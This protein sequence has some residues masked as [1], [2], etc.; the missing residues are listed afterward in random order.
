[1][2]SDHIYDDIPP[3]K[4]SLNIVISILMHLLTVNIENALFFPKREHHERQITSTLTN[5]K[6]QLLMTLYWVFDSISLNILSQC[7]DVIRSNEVH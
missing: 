3:Q 7:F 5:H 1:M 6:Q 2:I 4:K